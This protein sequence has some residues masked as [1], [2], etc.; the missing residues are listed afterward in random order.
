MG[1]ALFIP[2]YSHIDNRIGKGSGSAGERRVARALQKLDDNWLVWYDQPVGERNRRSDFILL[3]PRIGLLLLEVKAWRLDTLVEADP[4]QVALGTPTGLKKM[5]HPI[6]QVRSQMLGLVRRLQKIPLL[7]QK[8]GEHKGNLCMPYGHAVAFSHINRAAF[9]QHPLAE[10]FPQ[11]RLLFQ[12][13]LSGSSSTDALEDRLRSLFVPWFPCSLDEEQLKQVRGVVFPEIVIQPKQPD[14]LANKED[15][16]HLMKVMDLEQEKLARGMGEGHR[17][18]HGVAGS[19]KTMIL[20]FRARQLLEQFQRKTRGGQAMG[21]LLILCFTKSLAGYIR[22]L[23]DQWG[24]LQQ[25]EVLH[26]HEWRRRLCNALH[27]ENPGIGDGQQQATDALLRKLELGATSL[28]YDAILVDEGHDFQ[29]CWLELVVGFV[30]NHGHLLLLYDDTQSIYQK[31]RSLGFSLSSVGIRA[32]GRTHIL[33][34]NYRNTRQTLSTALHLLETFSPL[35]KSQGDIPQIRPEPY[36]REG[37]WP[38][39]DILPDI[40]GEALAL[41]NE[42]YRLIEAGLQP[43]DIAILYRDHP[44]GKNIAE[45]LDQ[46]GIHYQILNSGDNKEGYRVHPLQVNMMTMHSS[47]GLEFPV[48]L[49]AQ[50][51]LHKVYDKNGNESTLEDEARLRYVAMTRATEHLLLFASPDPHTGQWG[52]FVEPLRQFLQVKHSH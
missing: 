14:L 31:N 51:G 19:G 30:K 6:L 36:R 49:V 26:F 40:Q 50:M 16:R 4:D 13:E 29:P 28:Q 46:R 23:L 35:K 21:R 8:D 45:R 27:V 41:C 39:L 37:P 7:L 11:E 25:T 20:L 17:V 32:R 18:V 5:P 38:E 48:V 1:L 43:G 22:S 2:S 33:K 12:D 34:I 9:T 3:H 52:P 24:L 10:A 15:S 44:H 47:K 42:T